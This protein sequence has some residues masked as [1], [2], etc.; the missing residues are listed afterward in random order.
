[1]YSRVTPF[2]KADRIAGTHQKIDRAARLILREIRS[3][4][5]PKSQVH[6]PSINEIL[7]FEGSGG[8]DGIKMKSPGKDEPWHFVNPRG[9]YSAMMTY[10]EN[11][12]TNLSIAL[13]EQNFVRA[14][15][16]AGWMAHAITD[17][18][19]PAHQYPMEDKIIEISGKHPNER[20]KLNQKMFL[21]G[22]TWRKRLSANWKYLGPKG[23]MSSHMLY[24]MGV[25]VLTTSLSARKIAQK[26]S[27]QEITRLKNGEFITMFED[28]IQFV[29]KKQY[30]QTFIRKGWT[31]RLARETRTILLPEISKLVALAWLEAIRRAELIMEQK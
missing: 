15:F 10:I 30:Y 28:S 11:H 31:S 21:P 1:M 18:L 24:E 13:S 6:F 22:D 25:A 12:L 14:S 17:A 2:E 3:L 19:T 4:A 16:E 7:R 23:V 27:P 5:L 26:P 8:P 20:I 9:D 29:A